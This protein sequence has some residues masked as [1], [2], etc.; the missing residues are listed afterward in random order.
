[1]GKIQRND[2]NE[3]EDDFD[4]DENNKDEEDT[5]N[6]TTR[7]TKTSSLRTKKSINSVRGNDETVRNFN[8]SALEEE[9]AEFLYQKKEKFGIESIDCWSKPI[10]LITMIKKKTTKR[11]R[12]CLR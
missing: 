11:K 2:T 12:M 6:E 7:T 5:K 10:F 1:M 3:D 8:Q 4:D 9:K